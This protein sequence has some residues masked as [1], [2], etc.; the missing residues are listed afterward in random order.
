METGMKTVAGNDVKL[1]DFIKCNVGIHRLMGVVTR[2]AKGDIVILSQKGV[3][4]INQCENIFI[5]K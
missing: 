3:Y 2:N 4:P 1:G 5:T